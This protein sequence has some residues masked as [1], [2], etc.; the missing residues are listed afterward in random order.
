MELEDLQE[1]TRFGNVQRDHAYCRILAGKIERHG[2]LGFQK[3]SRLMGMATISKSVPR[4]L[5]IVGIPRVGF[6]CIKS[7]RSDAIFPIVES[8]STQPSNRCIPTEFE[9]D[10][11]KV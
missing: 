9:T 7:M 10:I 3:F 4:N 2:R 8:R 1:F 6:F 11:E 5:C